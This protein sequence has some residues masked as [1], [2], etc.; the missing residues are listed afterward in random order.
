MKRM[1]GIA[2][3]ILGI[4]SIF[5]YAK[6]TGEYPVDGWEVQEDDSGKEQETEEMEDNSVVY[7]EELLEEEK[8]CLDEWELEH[9]EAI[10]MS[11]H[12]GVTQDDINRIGQYRHL[13][14]LAIFIYD[15]GLDLSPLSN[16]TELETIELLTSP[17]HNTDV[18]FLSN[19]TELKEIFIWTGRIDDYSFFYSLRNLREIYI[20]K[21]SGIDDLSFFS[22]MPN[23]RSLDIVN[24]HDADLSY[25][26]HLKNIEKIHVGGRQI[27]NV[28]MLAN[29]S[30]VKELSL[31]EYGVYGEERLTFDLHILDGMAELE[32]LSL[33]YINI[34]DISPLA[35]K[36]FLRTIILVD[37]GIGDIEALKNLNN[38]DWLAIYGNKSEKV[39]EQSELYINDIKNVNVS[40]KIP[41]QYRL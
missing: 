41:N 33:L 28:E 18:S 4:C 3:V 15:E 6:N 8:I 11:Y 24:V 10:S 22:D 35:G 25:L 36:Q 12:D 5:L 32:S 9:V 23:L 27:R 29:L 37:T 1:V 21:N 20:T 40:E 13:K 38:L 19:L 17:M 30:H 39:K 7:V 2:I 31:F 14:S 34:E 26:A 16:L